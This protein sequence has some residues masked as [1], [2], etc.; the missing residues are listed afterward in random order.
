MSN[1]KNILFSLLFYIIYFIKCQKS[2]NKNNLRKNSEKEES[3]IEEFLEEE[4]ELE[5]IYELSK[6][7]SYIHI[8]NNLLQYCEIRFTSKI[9]L[10]RIKS[11]TY[12]KLND[13]NI[14][15][16]PN[17]NLSLD[18]SEKII[19]IHNINLNISISDIQFIFNIIDKNNNNYVYNLITYSINSFDYEISF[20][21]P[22]I[23]NSENIIKIIEKNNNYDFKY[24]T[25]IILLNRYN[26]E[27]SFSN[28][29]IKNNIFELKLYLI[30]YDKYIIKSLV[31]DDINKKTF[32]NEEYILQD[33]YLEQDIFPINSN[34]ENIIISLNVITEENAI[35]KLEKIYCKI[36]E[37]T[38]CSNQAINKNKIVI[39]YEINNKIPFSLILI[40]KDTN[41]EY[42]IYFVTYNFDNNI[43]KLCI[44]SNDIK[45]VEYQNKNTYFSINTPEYINRNFTSLIDNKYYLSVSTF[46]N[47]ITIYFRRINIINMEIKNY[48]NLILIDNTLIQNITFDD[49][50]FSIFDY[51]KLILVYPINLNTITDSQNLKLT[52]EKNV[53]QKDFI[54]ISLINLE[55]KNT[56]DFIFD[57]ENLNGNSNII[58]GTISLSKPYENQYLN[59]S[60]INQCFDQYIENDIYIKNT[61][62][63]LIDEINNVYFCYQYSY[64][65]TFI[66]TLH[67]E[68]NS[69]LFT[70]SYIKLIDMSNGK[71]IDTKINLNNINNL[72]FSFEIR[73][74][75]I[76]IGKYKIYLRG[77]N[78]S[79]GEDIQLSEIS[80]FDI[81]FVENE[82]EIKE[83]TENYLI[84]NGMKLE[85]IEIKLEKKII[86][87]QINKIILKFKNETEIEMTNYS[88]IYNG[89]IIIV[90]TSNINF[91]EIGTYI[92]TVYDIQNNYVNFNV[93]TKNIFSLSN[94]IFF[95]NDKSN[96]ID[97]SITLLTD[98]F[99]DMNNEILD[100][101]NFRN[102]FYIKENNIISKLNCPMNKVSTPNL[103]CYYDII[104]KN[105][106]NKIYIY[107]S[108]FGT[109]FGNKIELYI[110]YYSIENF[111][112]QIISSSSLSNIIIKIYSFQNSENEFS[113]N[114]QI[115]NTQID[116]NYDNINYIYKIIYT[117]EN[118]STDSK[119]KLRI[120]NNN[121]EIF[122]DNVI[123]L[124]NDLTLLEISSTSIQ[125]KNNEVINITFNNFL[126][127]DEVKNIYL[128]NS[129]K[130][131]LIPNKVNLLSNNSKSFNF[132]LFNYD[133][134]F[135]NDNEKIF[136]IYYIN[137]CGNEISLNTQ[138]TIDN[139]LP[140]FNIEKTIYIMQLVNNEYTDENI[141]IKMKNYNISNVNLYYNK[142]SNSNNIRIHTVNY[143]TNSYY[144]ITNEP[145]NYIFKY[146]YEK[147]NNILSLP[148]N[149]YI[150][151]K[152][153]EIFPNYSV[154]NIDKCYYYK[155]NKN[156]SISLNSYYDINYNNID[157][158]FLNLNNNN[159][160]KFKKNNNNIYTY[161]YNENEF[162]QDSI[163]NILI[164]ENDIIIYQEPKNITF[165]N[166]ITPS[167]II[168]GNLNFI[169][170]LSSNINECYFSFDYFLFRT[171]KN[172]AQITDQSFQIDC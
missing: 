28:F 150:I 125:N 163:F 146:S 19:Y 72:S 30:Q 135:L 1:I 25:K 86:I 2:I 132:D 49:F 149:I 156:F 131:K 45:R 104:N 55:N 84:I 66:I 29:T 119:I 172:D 18:L 98:N 33:F 148:Y 47:L 99:K 128:I 160:Y 158:Q 51:N 87:E 171:I 48:N 70:E 115:N 127:D 23:Q 53:N 7:T 95:I 108:N 114:F 32:D 64:S 106:G 26:E 130:I 3:E 5:I 110:F 89:E 138:I 41:N 167:Y 85:N 83:N 46:S 67:K 140:V 117:P 80:N 121:K 124:I 10:S 164:T 126:F 34:T 122:N 88:L 59:I 102:R 63:Y 14:I 96:Q 162:F 145:G 170:S 74:F 9:D 143:E 52:F 168:N 120:L 154:E 58:S 142:D 22:F 134:N 61:Y 75:D 93:I 116:Y 12:N 161:S 77:K 24:L 4:T 133:F 56:D 76:E 100:A 105:I 35:N 141:T 15:S 155:Q 144:L 103:I 73:A 37:T 90:D 92:F 166:L 118:I 60:L 137:Y 165:L 94:N 36:L 42:K 112:Q 11:I 79:N 147:N 31:E 27:I 153:N 113:L 6:N 39:T 111:C 109:N 123:Y 21:I 57:N 13:E 62:L 151:F 20:P 129:Q 16:I 8:D 139:S 54:K 38:L 44:V 97:L 50:S 107:Y 91:D 40:D 17:S 81:Y 169:F 82:I 152:I 71:E 43:N 65:Q 68:L 157:V 78:I 136:N 101:I 159:L 69:K